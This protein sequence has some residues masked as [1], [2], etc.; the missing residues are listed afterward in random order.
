MAS[1]N[2]YVLVEPLLTKDED[3]D[4]LGAVTDRHLHEPE[5]TFEHDLGLR[6][7]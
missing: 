1:K 6:Q 7:Q 2:A 4:E 3:R 5:A